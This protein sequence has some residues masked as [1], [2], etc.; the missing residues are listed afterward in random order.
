MTYLSLFGCINCTHAVPN[1]QRRK[2]DNKSI[3]GIFLGINEES[4]VY[5]LYDPIKKKIMIS[6]DVVF[7]ENENLKWDREEGENVICDSDED[8]NNIGIEM[9][10]DGNEENQLTQNSDSSPKGAGPEPDS[11]PQTN[12]SPKLDTAVVFR[13]GRIIKNPAHLDDFGM[14]GNLD[15]KDE[16][17]KGENI[18]NFVVFENISDPI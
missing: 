17:Q 10:T 4:K 18:H 1:A 11:K 14:L 5:R 6:K 12:T 9:N 15:G 16:L 2:M 8:G 13:A 7:D 3:R